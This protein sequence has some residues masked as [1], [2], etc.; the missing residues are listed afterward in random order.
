MEVSRL[1][2]EFLMLKLRNDMKKEKLFYAKTEAIIQRYFLKIKES[3]IQV[4]YK[5]VFS[6]KRRDALMDGVINDT[7]IY[8]VVFVYKPAYSASEE[9]IV[10]CLSGRTCHNRGCGLVKDY[11]KP[12]GRQISIYRK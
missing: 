3:E 7:G 2:L 1:S 9:E 5:N 8:S 10:D 12:Y 6:T 4:V 11:N